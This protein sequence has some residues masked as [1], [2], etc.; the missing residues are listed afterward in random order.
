MKRLL[1][2]SALVAIAATPAFARPLV[3][4]HVD[5]SA[6]NNIG[7]FNYTGA[8]TGFGGTVGNGVISFDSDLTNLYIRFTPGSALND[9]VAI[10]L[11]TRAGGFTD[12]DMDDQGDGGRRALSQ[13]ANAADD[14]F[15]PNFLPDFGIVVGGFGT[16]M[17]EL[18][19]GNTPNHLIFVDDSFDGSN[20]ILTTFYS[21]PLA[22]LGM[23][24]GDAVDFLVAYTSDGGYM[25]NES[26]PAYDALQNNGNPGFGDGQ[27]GGTN[28]SPGI[29][30]YNR[31]VTVPTPGTLALLGVGAMLA[32]RR[33]R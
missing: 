7:T 18:T 24:A 31:F 12:A 15:D 30:N 9:L 10:F 17:F 23:V 5:N 14:A 28:G 19:A 6:S 22:T 32:G 4:T 20:N 33:R 21:I 2:V 25:S 27:F 16:V 1:S 29:G 3:T 26:I 13:L 8:G 11:D